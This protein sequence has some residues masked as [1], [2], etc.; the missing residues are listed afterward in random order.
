MKKLLALGLAVAM[1]LSMGAIVLA[2]S[3]DVA[4]PVGSISNSA[5]L[6]NSDYNAVDMSAALE[7]VAYGKTIYYPLIN[8]NEVTPGYVNESEAVSGIKIRQ[9]WEENGNLVD[10]VNI[11]K[12]KVM[13]TSD[14]IYFVE[15][16]I[17]S[18]TSTSESAGNG[19][20]ALRKTGEFDYE[21]MQ[22]DA[23]IVVKYP[24]AASGDVITKDP[25]VFKE[26]AGFVGDTE[27]EFTFASDEDSYFVVNTVGQGKLL[28]AMST[29]YD[30]AVADKYPEA[31]L[32]FIY[33][34]GATFNKPG[35]LSIAADEDSYLYKVNSNGNLEKVDA[36]YDEYEEAFVVKTRT[37]GKYVISD[38]ELNL[39]APPVD[40]GTD[41]GTDNGSNNPSTGACI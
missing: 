3:D 32:D 9:D 6:L 35:T 16:V 15:G 14:Y 25:Q 8:N 30:S 28:L 36:E 33:G 41:N 1:V 2:A 23:N 40:N 38:V 5:Y 12:K 24:A 34:N 31:N 18:S 10:S 7:S 13:G 4:N 22:L 21:D 29:K 19:T 37:L 20:I 17:K 27:E 39:V 11:V 26:G